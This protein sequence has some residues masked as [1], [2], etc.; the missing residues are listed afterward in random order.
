MQLSSAS[1]DGE[2]AAK[3]TKED[4]PSVRYCIVLLYL[5]VVE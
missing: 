5:V 2:P 1:D 3:R 4:V